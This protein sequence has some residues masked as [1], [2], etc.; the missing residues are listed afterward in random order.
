M[1]VSSEPSL[2]RLLGT[3]A[4]SN[5]WHLQTS[6]S[7]WDAMERVHSAE[8]FN[9]VI[10]DVQPA[11]GR[12]L[13]LL[14]WLKRLYPELPIA[15]ICEAADRNSQKEA[16]RMG[17]QAIF[18]RPVRME[19]L[20]SLVRRNLRQANQNTEVDVAGED[21]EVLGE[22]EFFLSV[23]PVMQKVRIQAELLA[24]TELPVLILGEPGSGKGTVAHL[25]HKLSVHGGFRFLRVNCSDM[26]ADLLDIE[27]FGARKGA[28]V[29]ATGP[30]EERPVQVSSRL[31]RTV[32]S[33]WMR[34]R[35]CRS[36]CRPSYCRCCRTDDPG[37]PAR[38]GSWKSVF[39]FLQ[40]VA[41]KWIAR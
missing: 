41:T 12:D 16:T 38:A 6:R 25:I 32:L 22:D 11:D 37:T 23:S 4:Q 15:V 40:L 36:L 2:V 24:Q 26:P 3:A 9:L 17:A 20:E 19:Q 10:L 18:F 35:R 5:G 7:A 29:G 39:E 27:L 1:L 31:E 34:S 8:G 13:H 30:A 33:C 14:L 28:A 21:I